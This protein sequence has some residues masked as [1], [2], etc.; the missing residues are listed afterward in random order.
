MERVS[1]AH[2]IAKD[3]IIVPGPL[4]RPHLPPPRFMAWTKTHCECS[5]IPPLSTPFRNMLIKFGLSPFQLSPNSYSIIAGMYMLTRMVTDSGI[6]PLEL[7]FF[8]KLKGKK[9]SSFYNLEANSGVACV[10]HLK[11]KAGNWRNSW[12]FVRNPH[13][14]PTSFQIPSKAISHKV[15]CHCYW[16]YLITFIAFNITEAILRTEKSA[17]LESLNLKISCLDSDEVEAKN[18]ITDT[19]LHKYNMIRHDQSI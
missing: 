3:D 9:G 6:T 2:G 10:K 13:N 12:F 15:I 11:N 19:N 16:F 7:S 1:I 18:L 5:A 8:Y 14:L 17:N 4:D